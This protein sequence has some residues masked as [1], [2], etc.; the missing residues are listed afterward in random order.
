MNQPF[1]FEKDFEVLSFQI[2]PQGNLRWSCLADLMQE[3]A[4]RHADS[5][6]FGQRLFEQG[7]MWVMSRFD[8]QVSTLPAWGEKIVVKTAGRGIDKLFALRAFEVC[9]AR[10]QVIA[11]AMSAWL[12]LDIQSKRPQRPDKV[13][14]RELF[15]AVKEPHLIPEKIQL[16]AGLLE[17]GTIQVRHA[18]LDMNNHVNNVS[19]IRWI[20]DFARERGI[21]FDSLSINY[22]AEISA[23]QIIQLKFRQD[24]STMQVVGYLADKPVFCS[25]VTISL[26]L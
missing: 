23:G 22:L 20:E 25:S 2:D 26:R 3:V 10:G 5:R 24:G 9:N 16:A 1:Q 14:P 15:A 4:W 8:I 6:D 21:N 19:Y 13:L 18:D 12:L 7:L 17:A 11:S